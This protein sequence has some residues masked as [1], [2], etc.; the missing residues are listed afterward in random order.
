M[1]FNFK[2]FTCHFVISSLDFSHLP[3]INRHEVR[4]RQPKKATIVAPL[5]GGPLQRPTFDA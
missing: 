2:Q 3:M 1:M 5:N 4:A